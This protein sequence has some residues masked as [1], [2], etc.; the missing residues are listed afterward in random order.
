MTV[1]YFSTSVYHNKSN[2]IPID[3]CLVVLDFQ[4]FLND[5]VNS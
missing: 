2:Q 5:K 1:S 4:I 3:G